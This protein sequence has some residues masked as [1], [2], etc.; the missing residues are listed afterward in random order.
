MLNIT[1]SK[2]Q[3]LC[4]T[5]RPHARAFIL[6]TAFIGFACH[7][8]SEMQPER[9]SLFWGDT[10]LHTNQSVDAYGL[11]NRYLTPDEAYRFAKG[12]PV[13]GHNGQV[14]QLK[15]P[16]DFLL[17]AD[18]AVN[19]GVLPSLRE[20]DTK[21]KGPLAEEWTRHLAKS[22]ADVFN[23]IRQGSYEKYKASLAAADVR[24][25]AGFFWKSWTTDYFDDEAF[26]KEVWSEV[27]SL[28]DQHNIPGEFTAFIG[29]EWTPMSGSLRSPNFHR[30]VLYAGSEAEACIKLPFTVQDS[31]NVE[32]LWAYLEDYERRTGSRVLA[33]PHNGNLTNGKMFELTQYDGSDADLEYARNRARWEPLY[34][35][36]QIKGDSETHPI[37]SP[38]DPF[39]DFET[40]H[41]HGFFGALSDD[42]ERKK[43]HEYAR[44]A[45]QIGL[46]SN[47]TL[48]TNPFKFGLIGSSDAH[49]SLS[50]ISESDF[51]GKVSLFEPSSLRV[52]RSW[53]YSASGLAAVWA[54]ENTREA[55]FDALQRKEVYAT[56][57]TRI[58]LRVFAS[59]SLAE[60][61]LTSTDYVERGYQQGVPM[62]GDLMP[63]NGKHS[64]GPT[65]LINAQKD[66]SGAN[67][68]RIQVIKG[69]LD[70]DGNTHEKIF[71]V[72]LSDTRKG[73]I[74]ADGVQTVGN[75]VDLTSAT[76]TNDIGS[77]ILKTAWTDPEFNAQQSSFY[78]VRVLEIPTPRWN[79]YDRVRF[80]L[81]DEQIIEDRPYG[82]A[83]IEQTIPTVLQERAYSSPIWYEASSQ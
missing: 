45:L 13:R 43:R 19:M 39:A 69:W 79:T 24:D 83:G 6:T 18:H 78:Y 10:H 22:P 77:A 21:L 61:D 46:K 12:E 81:S 31:E 28:A 51:W 38:D 80:G 9:T 67:L 72:A 53:H 75:T 76:Y 36:T 14:A 64:N 20:Y 50:A 33:I 15:Q 55:V 8:Q 7:A 16:L 41:R 49:T 74:G 35:V 66:P 65:L 73:V 27:C 25:P 3:L 52:N 54:R 63:P 4:R 62:G 40:W 48:G 1:S 82:M 23:Y 37:L 29:Y 44:S 70:S 68:D 34:E 5:W 71:N 17:I 59:W 26:R 57:G 56:T 60:S 2:I 30:N 58:Q 11:G 32:D 42:F 47:A